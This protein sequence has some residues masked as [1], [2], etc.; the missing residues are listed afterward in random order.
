MEQNLSNPQSNATSAATN[1]RTPGL[2][3][4]AGGAMGLCALVLALAFG[5]LLKPSLARAE[6]S[7]DLAVKLQESRKELVEAEEEKR[8]IL[9]SIY[10]I[11]Q[12]MRKISNRK[13][14]LTNDL[15][16]VQDNVKHLSKIIAGL[17]MQIGKQRVA[18]RRRLRTLYKLSGQEYVAIIFAA[19]NPVEL[20][21]VMRFLKIVT[22]NDYSLIRNYQRNVAAYKVQKNK[23]RR[24]VQK[25]VAIEQNIKKQEGMLATEHNAK[26][27][28]VSELDQVKIANLNRIKSIRSKSATIAR[29]ETGSIEDLLKPSIYEQRG[30]LVHPMKGEVV[31]E[32]GLVE[33]E[34]YKIR[35]SHKGWLYQGAVSAPVSAIFEGT[36]VYADFVKGYGHTVIVDHGDHYYSLY[37]RVGA[38][39]AKIGD[40]I[41]R[42]QVFAESGTPTGGRGT[43]LYFEIRHF[44]EPE[45]P[46]NW[47]VRKE[48]EASKSNQNTS[49]S[50]ASA[51]DRYVTANQ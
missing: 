2:R 46:A 42:G 1:E 31:Q 29:S 6:A 16:Q 7:K 22:D 51:R 41:R 12:R 24:Q 17:E 50:D 11:N 8:K 44:S 45:N 9:G 20:D 18:L 5:F 4:R 34:R 49:A 48:G 33:D 35:L 21:E 23:L 28:I 14:R 43:Q 39:R 13:S 15:F 27:K 40:V 3:A 47:I 37:A 32:F 19:Q 10:V 38:I 26:S 25:L 36:I 30:Q